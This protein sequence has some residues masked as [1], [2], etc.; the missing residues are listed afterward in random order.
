MT[1]STNNSTEREFIDLSPWGENPRNVEEL[2]FLQ[3]PHGLGPELLEALRIFS[4][5]LRGMRSLHDLG[6][7]VMVFGS[8][9]IGEEHPF[10]PAAVS[11]GAGL[12]RAGLSVL[13]RG[14]PGLME[15]VNRGAQQAGGRSIGCGM[16]L[17]INQ[18]H[19]RYIDRSIEFRHWFL[20]RLLILK[21]AC[22]LVALPDGLDAVAPIVEAATLIR[23]GRMKP[24]PV[25]LVGRSYWAPLL[26]TLAQ[27]PSSVGP[28]GP[29]SGSVPHVTDSIDEALQLASGPALELYDRTR[30]RSRPP[31]SS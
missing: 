30:G 22:A 17:H 24:L 25:V 4:D 5:T 23:S 31:S 1:D 14:G 19:N 10:Y 15:A 12:A 11:L 29:V 8:A 7:C 13:T 28:A 26:A 18:M 9:A 27:R 2:V 6:P 21:Y 16:K 3:G 20:W